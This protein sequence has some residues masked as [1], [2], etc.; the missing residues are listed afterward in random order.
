VAYERKLDD[1]SFVVVVPRLATRVGFP[2]VGEVWKDTS[3]GWLWSA[4]WTELFTGRGVKT[5]QSIKEILHEFPV[6]VLIGR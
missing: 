4:E 5:A 1:Q 6:A 3:L 2:P